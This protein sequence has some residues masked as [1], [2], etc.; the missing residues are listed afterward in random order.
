MSP[1]LQERYLAAA[2]ER[3]AARRRRRQP[4]RRS[5]HTYTRA[6]RTSRRISTSRGSRSAP[7][8]GAR[9]HH[10][11]PLDGEYELQDEA[12]SDQP[13][14][15]ARPAVGAPRSRVTLD[16]RRVHARLRRRPADAR[17]R[18]F[19]APTDTGD[20]IDKR[21]ST[22]LKVSC[23]R[24]RATSRWPSPSRRGRSSTMRLQSVPAE[25]ARHTSTGPAV[26]TS[27][28]MAITG[29]FD[30]DRARRHAEPPRDLHVPSRVRRLGE[31]ACATQILSTL[32]RRAYRQ[33]VD[34]RPNW[35]ARCSSSTRAAGAKGSF[36][37]GVQRGAAAR[38]SRARSSC[39]APSAS[40]RVRAGHGPS[41]SATSSWRRACRSSCGAAIPDDAAARGRRARHGS[42]QPAV[43]E[44]AG[45]PHAGRS[46]ARTR[47]SAT[48]PAS[49]CSCATCAALQPNSDDFPDFDD[50]LRQAFRRETELLFDSIM[51]E[52]RSVLDLLTRRLH[53]R[54]R[55]AGAALR[56]P[57]RLRQPVPPGAG[58]ATSAPGPAGPG[59]HPGRD[60][61]RRAHVAGAARQVGARERAGHC[62]R[63]RRRPT[64][65]R[66]T[67][68]D[69]PSRARCASRWPNTGRT[70]CARAATR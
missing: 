69:G 52:D 31:Q 8:G 39:S 54:Q 14:D 6:R 35:R 15:D 34:R 7:L 13:G 65:R 10:T 23:R 68:T 48:S 70:R 45:A 27:S 1:S 62:R 50:N 67:E 41:G 19:E 20:A 55:A 60:V 32:S 4:R 59:Q 2:A 37:T 28:R 33:P 51:H 12:L 49:G 24:A 53:V 40:P 18:A 57:E 22:R 9:L 30:D 5:E 11:F 47:S 38:R 25:R 21:V 26:R 63:R 58:D 66:S 43:L 44:R 16:G 64:C 56:H 42:R 29:P 17:R 36:E 46:A 61:A 3:R